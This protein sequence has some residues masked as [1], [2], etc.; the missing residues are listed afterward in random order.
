M[1]SLRQAKHKQLIDFP[2][3][4]VAHLLQVL[5]NTIQLFGYWQ[6]VLKLTPRLLQF[7]QDG[8][9]LLTDFRC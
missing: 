6:P 8:I 4:V 3:L 5:N 9:L 2:L 7:E 1:S